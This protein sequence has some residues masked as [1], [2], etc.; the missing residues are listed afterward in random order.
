[1]GDAKRVT[2]GTAGRELDV[3]V[4]GPEDGMALVF[5]SGTPSAAVRDPILSRAAEPRG[6][7]LIT[8]SRPGYSSSTPQPGRTVAD[9]VAD[10]AAVLDELGAPRFVT[11][12]H[13][14]AGPHALACAALMPDRC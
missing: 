8:W 1:M 4:E 2:V 3:L 7:R 5:H 6:V 14:G 13:S 9:V 12:G 11:I 10:A